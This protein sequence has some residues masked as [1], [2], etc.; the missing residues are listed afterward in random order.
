[1]TQSAGPW[2]LFSNVTGFLNIG[3]GDMAGHHAEP[4][5]PLDPNAWSSANSQDSIFI[6]RFAMTEL[7]NQVNQIVIGNNSIGHG[8]NTATIGNDEVTTTVLSPTI[9]LRAPRT[10]ASSS[11]PGQTGEIC[12]DAGFVYVCISP[13]VWRRTSLAAW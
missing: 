8:S 6:G 9:R 11:S 3:I 12:W 4:R 13:H 1:M 5:N 7:D 2:S 10:P